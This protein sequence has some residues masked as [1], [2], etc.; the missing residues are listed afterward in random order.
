MANAFVPEIPDWDSDGLLPVIHPHTLDQ[1]PYKVSS[2]QLVI[3]M[4]T[5]EK[6]IQLL[7]GWLN[8]RNELYVI[9]L[10]NGWQWVNGS[11]AQNV[12][13]SENRDPNDVDVVTFV[14]FPDGIDINAFFLQHERL[15]DSLYTKREFGVDAYYFDLSRSPHSWFMDRT[16]YWHNWWSHTRKN[17]EK[18][19]FQV[20]LSAEDDKK[21][22]EFLNSKGVK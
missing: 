16:R 8:L 11:F 18:G 17:E 6:R 13:K 4:G 2:E 7:R 9:G 3:A 19:Y 12:E 22:L 14:H 5:T 15:L 20:L 1:S 21:A 10:V